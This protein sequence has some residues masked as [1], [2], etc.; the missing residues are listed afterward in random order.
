M[1]AIEDIRHE[2]GRYRAESQSKPDL[3]HTVDIF[4]LGGNGECSC[5]DFQMRC[6]PNM[7]RHLAACD[8]TGQE[9]RPIPYHK[10][11]HVRTQC[12]HIRDGG[13][14]ALWQFKQRVIAREEGI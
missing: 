10:G 5:E 4:A 8:V 9:F 13:A 11:Y 12:K 14:E 3:P 7:E 2:A 6:L 1:T